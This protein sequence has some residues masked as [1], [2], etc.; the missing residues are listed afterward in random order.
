MAAP[1]LSLKDDF[2]LLELSGGFIKNALLSALL[3]AL[4]RDRDDPKLTEAD[5]RAGGQAS[6]QAEWTIG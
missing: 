5:V 6:V 2:M 3:F 4:K 1:K